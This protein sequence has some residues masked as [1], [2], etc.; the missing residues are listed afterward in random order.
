MSDIQRLV[1]L[2][3]RR[4]SAD[5]Y[6]MVRFKALRVLVDR[7][8]RRC[9][10]EG[11]SGNVIIEAMIEGYLGSHPAVLAMIDQWM[12]DHEREEVSHRKIPKL[13]KADLDE[14]H[15]AARSGMMEDDKED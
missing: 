4:N 9:V 6:T 15:A 10:E 2:A 3:A 11:M 13:G 5:E 8:R 7:F 12:R 14:I 1:R